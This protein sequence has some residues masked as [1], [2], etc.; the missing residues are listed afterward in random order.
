MS[1]TAQFRFAAGPATRE[2][3]ISDRLTIVVMKFDRIA[4]AANGDQ[5]PMSILGAAKM[6][7]DE[8]KAYLKA[9]PEELGR[10]T[11]YMFKWGLLDP[12][13][14]MTDP[15]GVYGKRPD[16]LEENEIGAHELT[17]EELDAVLNA[18]YQINSI[19]DVDPEKAAPFFRESAGDDG[20]GS[21]APPDGESLRDKAIDTPSGESDELHV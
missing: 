16:E 19:G 13:I 20:T 9:H 2:V 10:F 18:I 7:E 5:F 4:A 21:E 1:R 6:S 12:K 8:R 14:V 11:N 17:D 15:N 3:R